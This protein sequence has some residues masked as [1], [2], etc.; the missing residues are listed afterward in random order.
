MKNTFLVLTMTLFF[1]LTVKGQNLFF[2]G[3]NSYSCTETFTLQANSEYGDDLYVSIGKDGATG[4]FT[5]STI[6]NTR[7]IF[8]GK[9][10]IYLDDGTVITC[11]D[12]GTADHV[13]DRAKAVYFL[14]SKELNKMK[15]SNIN[16]VRYTLKCAPC[17]GF[18]STEKGNWSV[19][20]K[21]NK[22]VWY[23]FP[24]LI[25]EFFDG[26]WS[27]SNKGAPTKSERQEK[28]DLE[29]GT[30]ENE[31]QEKINVENEK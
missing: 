19:S 24:V 23:N 25:T 27:A 17:H 21:S 5:V 9:L 31:R 14:T 15:K 10:I 6:S 29:N 8:S 1:T 22:G 16:T 18:Y 2:M 4:L 20:N 12:R 30:I 28:G 11:I 7:V 13:D 3:E 26:N